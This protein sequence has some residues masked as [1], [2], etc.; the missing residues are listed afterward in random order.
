MRD[1]CLR[2][3][4]LTPEARADPFLNPGAGWVT[5][6]S[7]KPR[8]GLVVLYDT[9]LVREFVRDVKNHIDSGKLVVFRCDEPHE[10]IE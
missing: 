8:V 6:L 3:Y 1:Y 5:A 10:T 4:P 7:F 9:N 2:N